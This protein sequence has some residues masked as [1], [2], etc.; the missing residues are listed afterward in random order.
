[1]KIHMSPQ[2]HDKLIN[3]AGYHLEPRGEINV[4]GKGT[5]FTYFL[6]GKD[7]FHKR[8]PTNSDYVEFTPAR[9]LT[10]AG[11]RPGNVQLDQ[12]ADS[13][14]ADLTTR[15]ISDTSGQRVRNTSTTSDTCPVV[16]RQKK[17]STCSAVNAQT[18]EEKKVLEVPTVDVK[19]LRKAFEPDTI[20]VVTGSRETVADPS[21]LL[22]TLDMDTVHQK[23][24]SLYNRRDS[25]AAPSYHQQQQDLAGSVAVVGTDP[26]QFPINAETV[27]SR[28][29]ALNNSLDA[30]VKVDNGCLERERQRQLQQQQQHLERK[31]EELEG[32]SPAVNQLERL[33]TNPKA[34]V[35]V[36][37]CV[38]VCAC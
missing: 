12:G 26:S 18:P 21:E 17:L 29:H 16:T 15:R 31:L 20:S 8:L 9:K 37:V 24:N 22:P 19:T 6:V 5:M 38:C 3:N 25:E 7:G 35:C 32:K 33:F 13:L 2:A 14:Q 1:M 4:K 11:G 23:L 30:D 28:L 34:E 36:C 10:Q 27:R